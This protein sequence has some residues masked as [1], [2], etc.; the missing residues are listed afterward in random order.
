M[1]KG[2][3]DI[4]KQIENS[5]FHV[6]GASRIDNRLLCFIQDSLFKL[7]V[8]PISEAQKEIDLMYKA[9]KEASKK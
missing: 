7:R 8:G 5:V 4:I 1:L 3:K 2:E 6:N 9:I